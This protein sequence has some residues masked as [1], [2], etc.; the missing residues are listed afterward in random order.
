MSMSECEKCHEP[1]GFGCLCSTGAG[2][3]PANAKTGRKMQH[4]VGKVISLTN[5]KTKHIIER[6]GFAVTGFVL[7]HTDGRKCIVDMSAV[8]WFHDTDGRAF[9][10]MMH[11]ENAPN[12]PSTPPE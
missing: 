4:D 11:P 12:L 6:D 1:Y 2:N 7:T 10:R 9:F 8:R 5:Q 3:T